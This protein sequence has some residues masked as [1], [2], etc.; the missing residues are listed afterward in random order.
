MLENVSIIFAGDPDRGQR[1]QEAMRGQGW[2]MRC[3]E[4]P[5]QA[6]AR[7]LQYEPDLVIIDDFPESYQARSVFYQ[8]R[9]AEMGPFLVLNDSPGNLMFSRLGALSFLR[10]IKRNPEPADLINAI[11]CLIESNCESS[12]RQSRRSTLLRSRRR[13]SIS[14]PPAGSGAKG[15]CC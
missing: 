6:I 14:A 5:E 15:I 11:I 9:S 10:M 8:L 2:R 13:R 7:C 12:T 3:V 4:G 1:F